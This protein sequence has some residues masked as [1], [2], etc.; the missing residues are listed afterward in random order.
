MQTK[1]K[2]GDI[3]E[4]DGNCTSPKL[5]D[6]HPWAIFHSETQTDDVCVALPFLCP[7]PDRYDDIYFIITEAKL[8]YRADT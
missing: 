7:L 4:L 1:F 3:I 8:V 5:P 6:M 2:A